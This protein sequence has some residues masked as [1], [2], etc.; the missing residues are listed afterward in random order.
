MTR[1]LHLSDTHVS[2]AGPDEDGVDAVLSLERILEDVARVPDIDLVLV[3]GDIA[4][5]GSAQGCRTVR[6]RVE[7]FALARGVPH[8]Y[9]TGNH[10]DRA[11]FAAA[12]GS[13]HVGPGGE[14]RGTLLD[15]D[16][17]LRAAV[18]EVG[19]MRIITLDSL[20]PGEVQGEIGSRQLDWLATVLAT[21]DQRGTVIAFHHPPVRLPSL[22]WVADFVLQDIDAL[23]EVVRGRGVSAILTGH[24][25][26][27]VS[28]SLAGVPVW[29]TP[30]VVTGIDPTVPPHLIRAVLGA[31]ATIVDLAEPDSP[32]FTALAARDPRAGQ[33]VYLYDPVARRIV[34]GGPG[35]WVP[36][37]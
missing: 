29:V 27:Q 6:D 25:H 12:L 23:A 10:D 16:G 24:L 5:D 30:G 28:A 21:P 8:V 19:G 11:A 1:I 33:Q 22:P 2:A 36:E 3:S 7:D 18:S 9:T 15:P 14:D 20:I 34:A 31:S 26:F 4:D 32:T 35:G 17:D 37:P 13:G